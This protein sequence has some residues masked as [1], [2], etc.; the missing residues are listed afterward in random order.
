MRF[1]KNAFI[2]TSKVVILDEPTSG[3]DPYSRRLLWSLLKEKC[4][5]RV[6]LLTTH[7]MDEA[8]I[9]AGNVHVVFQEILPI[10]FDRFSLFLRSDVLSTFLGPYSIDL[11]NFEFEIQ[12]KDS[13]WLLEALH[14]DFC[15]T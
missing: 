13:Q 6:V 12:V 8:D 3:M 2:V 15:T 4:K 1:E 14:S 10:L 9:L 7:F 11:Q 5:N